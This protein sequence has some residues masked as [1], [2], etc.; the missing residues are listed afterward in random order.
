MHEIVEF[1]ERRSEFSKQVAVSCD[2][3][4]HTSDR[5]VLPELRK[6]QQPSLEDYKRK[7]WCRCLWAL[8]GW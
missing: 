1:T 4:R 2:A 6:Q 5:S 7:K 8:N 3:M